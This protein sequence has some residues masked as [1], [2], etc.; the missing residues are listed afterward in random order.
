MAGVQKTRVLRVSGLV[1]RLD[2]PDDS[3]RARAALQA[4]LSTVPL[5]GFRFVRRSLDAR[6]TRGAMHFVCQ[7]E[8]VIDAE[9]LPASV[10]RALRSGRAS[11]VD[12]PPE[13]VI[14]KRRDGV[15]GARAVVVGAGPAGI[16]AAWILAQNGVRVHVLERGA[17]VRDRAKRVVGF[18]RSREVD[19]ETN[20]LFG[21]GGAGT[22]SDGKLYTRIDDP[23][24]PLILEE[25]VACGAPP[26]I[27]YD[28]RA[29]IGTDK[30]HRVLPRLRARLEE[31]G[32]VFH[33]NTRMEELVLE[34]SSVRRV[35][36][37]RTSAG[38]LGCEA[39]F[40]APGHSARDTWTRL[41]AQGVLFEAKPFQLGVRI[42]HPQELVTRGRYGSGEEARLLGPASYNLVSRAS[43]AA[44]AAHSFCMCPG[45]KIVASVS[46]AGLLCT[47]GMSNSRHSSPWANAALVT[48]VQPA[49]FAAFGDGPFAGVALQRSLERAFFEAGGG[50]YCAPAQRASDFLAGRSTEDGRLRTSYVFGAVPARIDRLVPEGVRGAIAR[51]LVSFERAIP[52]FSGPEGLLVGLE[53]RSSGPVRIPRDPTTLRALGFANL[54]PCGEGAGYAGGITSAALDGVRAAKAWLTSGP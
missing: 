5:R 46:E 15:E 42:E 41:H 54:F 23:F 7:V 39:L 45:G 27:L 26:E 1:Q 31:R 30:L 28:A 33:W 51:A 43:E 38:E 19:P 14:E 8:L 50:N 25:L 4:G 11:E 49:D 3:L 53:S 52:G 17:D 6:R 20:L 29:H 24:E 9:P 40:L 48:T 37:A 2:E 32:V 47:N 35:R 10:A 36:A 16:F 13:P 18:H 44:A 12:P 21:E 34:E 22:F